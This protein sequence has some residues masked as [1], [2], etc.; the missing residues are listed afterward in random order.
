M[1]VLRQAPKHCLCTLEV[2]PW[3]RKSDCVKLVLHSFDNGDDGS[4]PKAAL[5]QRPTET[6]TNGKNVQ[7]CTD[8]IRRRD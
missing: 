5:I 6:W 4:W 3:R 7:Y 2:A 8:N 1:V